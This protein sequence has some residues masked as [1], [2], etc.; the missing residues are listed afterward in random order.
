[1][2]RHRVP[3]VAVVAALLAAVFLV[4][5]SGP[6][7]ASR[8]CARGAVAAVIAGKHVCLAPGRPCKHSLASAYARYGFVCNAS[9]RL[10]KKPKPPPAPRKV[11]LDV[12]GQPQVVFNW[13]TQRCEDLDIPDLPTRVFRDASGNVQLIAAHFRNRRFIGP[14]LDHLAH[15]C[16]LIL[17]SAGNADPSA[18]DDAEWIAATYSPDGKTVYALIHDEYHGWEHPGQCPSSSYYTS[19]CWYNTITLA[20]STDGGA[21]YADQPQPRVVASVPYRYVPDKGPLGMFSPSNIVHNP[22]DNYYYALVYL[23]LYGLTPQVGTCLI[24]TKNLAD[25]TSWR[26]WSGGHSFNTS[27]VDP[28]RSQDDPNAHLCM[29]LHHLGPGDMQPGSLSYSTVARQWLWVG[30]AIGGAYF[31]QSSDLINWTSPKLFFPA[32][33]TWNYQC[34]NA[35][36][37][38][39]PTLIDPT[40]T[41]RNFDTVG[42]TAYVYFTQFHPAGCQLGLN[43]D[44]MRLEV[45]VRPAP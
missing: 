1:M 7:A 44:L 19:A 21:T 26:A 11:A 4:S 10:A 6:S 3:G 13:S 43:R 23:N 12:V 31:S 29:P 45:Q 27:F 18:F 37:I 14:N 9:G 41:S 5:A 20:V 39:Y 16:S 2:T 40:S 33:V 30:Q 32:Q 34:G 8:T 35:D 28:Y 42:D 22:T 25:P 38:E 17:N 36:P 15:P 24:R